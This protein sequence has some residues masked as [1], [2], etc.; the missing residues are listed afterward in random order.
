MIKNLNAR[1]L[2]KGANKHGFIYKFSFDKA[3]ART[4]D[5]NHKFVKKI[6]EFNTPDESVLT[7][8]RVV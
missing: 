3:E 2:L 7:P 4:L 6:S 5:H 8:K 1:Q